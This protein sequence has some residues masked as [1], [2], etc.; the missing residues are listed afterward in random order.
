MKRVVF[1]ALILFLATV[2]RFFRLDTVP[3]LFQSSS[4][5]PRL[6][7]AIVSI[8]NVY[9]TCRL[10]VRYSDKVKVGLL[11]AFFMGILPWTLEESRVY[12]SVNNGLAILLAGNFFWL[13]FRTRWIKI[14][15]AIISLSVFFFV[16]Q[17]IWFLK[18][19][20][21]ISILSF[22]DNLFRLL[23][24]QMWFFN[25]IT[26]YHGG[27]REWGMV[28][29]SM[30]PLL[31]LGL[32]KSYNRKNKFLYLVFLILSLISAMSPFFPE[33][34]EFF[35]TTPI[36]SFFIGK[37][38]YVLI[39]EKKVIYSLITFILLLLIVYEISQLLHFYYNHYPLNVRESADKIYEPF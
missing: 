25:N 29:I 30:L 18:N 16:Y 35:L 8:V 6:V 15:T 23:S 27:L 31:I 20:Q 38:F 34:R 7:T 13:K 1:L 10:S 2:L 39:S 3:P 14:F 19:F 4:F 21:L 9:L 12:S 36:L 11:S 22:R 5:L 28:Y 37:G 33:S 32:I 26:F 24:P 17:D